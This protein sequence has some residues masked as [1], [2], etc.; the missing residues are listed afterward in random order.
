MIDFDRNATAPLVEAAGIAMRAVLDDTALGNPS[1]VHRL[2]QRARAVVERG[3]RSVATSLGAAA[4][5]VVF[6]SGG[7]EAD[8]LALL[9][10][11]EWLVQTGRPAG[12][13]CSAIEHPAVTGAAARL[14][15]RGHTVVA[16]GVDD[17]GRL[18]PDAVAEVVQA[19]PELGV[20]SITAAH[21]ELGNV[22]DVPAIVCAIRAV[23]RDVVVHCDAVSAFGKLPV[24]FAQWDVDL[25]AVAAHKIGGPHGIGALV[26]RRGI[27]VV[28]TFD[29]GRQQ[30]GRRP[31]TEAPLLVAGFAA[32]AEHAVAELPQWSA[33]V[34]PAFARLRAG[35]VALGAHTFGD[36]ERH[37]GNTALVS[38]AGCD[39]HLVMMAL[40]DAGF[41][42]S[43]GAACS[44]GTIE[45]SAVL[46][47]LGCP[48]ALA[49]TAVRF[50]IGHG[51]TDADID[52]LL[53]VLPGVLA[54]VR[55]ATARL[56][57]AS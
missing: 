49:R 18:V 32:A 34:V 54:N 33:R 53:A 13:A 36:D 55:G 5:E 35:L 12:L 43:T 52:G 2:G 28:P 47:A 45:P 48:P 20:V 42:V 25:L 9:G 7:T 39:G 56:E 50:S 15:R 24:A 8:G 4:S 41:A 40:D 27:G 21:H 29:G 19:H 26:V 1:S 57:A 38:F 51:H 6:T 11:V 22:T 23:R 44:A 3:R 31:G 14:R 46:L 30:A 37:L 16:L 17:K 10:A